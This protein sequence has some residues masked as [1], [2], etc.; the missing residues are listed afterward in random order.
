MFI[1]LVQS[2]QVGYSIM[3]DL[4]DQEFGVGGAVSKKCSCTSVDDNWDG[5]SV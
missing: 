5:F 2:G 3:P 1:F 4:L